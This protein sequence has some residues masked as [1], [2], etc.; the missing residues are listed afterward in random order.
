MATKRVRKT[1]KRGELS[2]RDFW[3][4]AIGPKDAPTPAEDH[5]L[6]ALWQEHR[7]ALMSCGLNGRPWAAERYG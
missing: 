3:T 2:D 7:E 1:R 5:R 4:L 6:K